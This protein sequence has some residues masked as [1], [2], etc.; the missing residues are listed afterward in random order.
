MIDE[1]PFRHSD[2][3]AVRMRP[4][5]AL[6]H[7]RKLIA[8]KEDTEQ[9]FHIMDA[10][11]SREFERHAD[12]FWRSAQGE[13][14]MKEKVSLV[15]RLDDHITLRQL[16]NDSLG[17]AY[18][19]FMERE[20]LSAQGLV[21][22]YDRFADPSNRFDDLIERYSDRMRDM[23]DLFHVLTG[24]GRD[25]LGEQCV[26][27]FSHSQDPNFGELFIAYA[28]GY[29]VKKD[30]PSEVPVYRAIREAQVQ[31]RLAKHIG[32]Q[33]IMAFLALP[34]VEARAKLNIKAPFTYLRCHE[35]MDR[36]DVNPYSLLS[37]E[38]GLRTY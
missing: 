35:L 31:G 28:G 26:L 15:E 18:C 19:D 11:G 24:Y 27:A 4:L 8:D 1:K 21:D 32:R 23:H 29:V 20:G 25:A 2:R 5:K 7:F 12:V 3:P 16:P 17:H 34:L 22:E 36:H 14:T 33:D 38:T 10:L 37:S 30:L 6:Y 13:A 9:V